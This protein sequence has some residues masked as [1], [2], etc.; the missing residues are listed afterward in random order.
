[1]S[2]APH[3][4]P[5]APRPPRA[6]RQ[7]A[8]ADR[9]FSGCVQRGIDSGEFRP[10]PVHEVAQALMAPI[11]FMAIHRHSFGACPVLGGVNV[12]PTL[13]LNTHLEL[14]LRGL[15]VRKPAASA[16]SAASASA[17]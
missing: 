6:P 16:A 11:I 4:S 8:P 1:M 13:V 15:E 5:R 2:A 3:S 9:L 10:M 14:V 17:K 7:P 12:E